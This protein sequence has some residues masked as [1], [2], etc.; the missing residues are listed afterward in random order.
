MKDCQKIKST[1]PQGYLPIS[2]FSY[3]YVL[4]IHHLIAQFLFC[5]DRIAIPVK[6]EV[7]ICWE[8]LIVSNK[9]MMVLGFAVS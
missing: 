6:S 7:Q 5:N 3:P 2:L 8:G 9:S 4:P 1:G